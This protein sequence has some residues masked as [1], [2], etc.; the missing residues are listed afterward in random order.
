[1]DGDVELHGHLL[2]GRLAP[3]I[4]GELGGSPAHRG[5]F[6]NEVD[7]Q[8]DGF[9]LVGQRALHALLDPPGGVG[10]EFPTFVRIEPHDG[11]DEPDVAFADQVE[12]GKAK[13]PVILRDF[14]HETQ[15]GL[16]HVIACRLVAPADTAGQGR[17]LGN[18]E[19]RRF[20]NFLE[21]K[22]QV[23]A[24]QGIGLGLDR[25]RLR[26][27][28]NGWRSVRRRLCGI[29]KV[30]HIECMDCPRRFG[31]F[32]AGTPEEDRTQFAGVTTLPRT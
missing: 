10:A 22:L 30:R 28:K 6:A 14:H 2:V 21:I 3:K 17:L 31:D 12:Q 29:G 8:T 23:A 18:G 20:A 13:I 16:D 32:S 4:L 1:M 5:D 7:G 25:R 15:V 27:V 26:F 24:L 19:K 9:R 11:L